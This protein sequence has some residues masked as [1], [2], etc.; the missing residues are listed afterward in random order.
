MGTGNH[1]PLQRPLREQFLNLGS[2]ICLCPNL[3]S[4]SELHIQ[5]IKVLNS[6][7]F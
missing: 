3:I 6:K 5:V 2:V 1:V 7:Y 4:L